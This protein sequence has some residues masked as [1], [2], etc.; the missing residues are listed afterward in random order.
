MP[1]IAQY[2]DYRRFLQD[3]YRE[4][5]KNNRSFSYQVLAERAGM[6]SKGFLHNV[7]QGKRALTHANVFGLAQAMKLD[8]AQTD[9]LDALVGFNN[10]ATARQRD[11]YYSKLLSVRS[12]GRGS[13]RPQMVRR[14]QY[15]FYANFHHSVIRS[16][17][18]L[19]GYSGDSVALARSVWPRITPAKARRS[20][21]LLEKLGLVERRADGSYRVASKSITTPP[22]VA[23]V[24][25][26]AFHE[27]AGQLALR[28][29][30][31]LPK[32]TRNITA[33]TLG[34][35]AAGYARVCAEIEALRR[36]LVQAAETDADA[37]RVYQLNFQ[38]FPVST[39]GR[40]RS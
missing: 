19:A 40:G 39:N 21:A 17:I 34:I 38:F 37:D 13:W 14:D 24:A 22:E 36:R 5:K 1:D 9:Y 12:R 31:E 6:S 32:D 30:N 11:Y 18:D 4:R 10:A 33:V 8:H 26:R 28:A 7:L 23:D 35:S 27:Q 3:Y 20:V 29:L 16:L 15:E 25:V 2:T